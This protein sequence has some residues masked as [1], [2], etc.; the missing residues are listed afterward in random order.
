MT[1]KKFISM[2]A[3]MFFLFVAT[4]GSAGCGGGHSSLFPYNKPDNPTGSYT[5]A[6][7]S[8]GG[9]EIESQTVASG[10][11]AIMPGDP[12]KDNNLFMGWYTAEGFSFLFD[13]ETPIYENTVLFAKWYDTTDTTDSDGDGLMDSLEVMFGT[14]PNNRD[15]D[16]DGLTDYEELNWLN[17]N[18]LAQDTDGN[19]IP[20]GDEDPDGDMLLNIEEANL[21]TSFIMIDTDHD[22]I[23]DYDEVKIFKTNPLKAD[24]D[25]DGVDDGVEIALGT[26]PLIAETSFPTTFAT[27]KIS[28]GD[29]EAVDISVSVISSAEGAGTLTVNQANNTNNPLVSVNMPGY[30]AA[31]EISAKQFDSA[32]ITFTIGKEIGT[33]NENFQPTIYYLNEETGLL[34]E[35]EDQI[36]SGNKITASVSHFSIYILL[37][38]VE[39]EEAWDKDIKPPL[40]GETDDDEEATL[41]V[42]FVIDCSGSMQDN[43]RDR[44]APQLSKQFVSKLRDNQDKAAVVT[45]TDYATIRCELTTDKNKLNSAIDN[46]YYYGGTNGS[47]GLHSAIM[48]L[49][50]S[51]SEYK[52]VIFLTDGDDNYH[53]YSYDT[54]IQNASND[55][56]V[57]YTIGMGSAVETT[58]KKIADGTGGKYYKATTST[59]TDDILDLTTV[60]DEI[61]AETIDLTKDENNDGIP[62][63]YAQLMNDGQIKLENKIP[64]FTG[65]LDMYGDNDDWDGDGLKNGEEINI[66]TVTKAGDTE[67]YIEMKSNPLLYDSDFDGYSDYQEVIEMKTNPF[68]TTIAGGTTAKIAT[69]SVSST[70]FS[71]V[72]VADISKIS[73]NEDLAKLRDDDSFA[74]IYGYL[75]F[76][77][78]HDPSSIFVWDGNSIMD[79]DYVF[80]FHKDEKVM[81][82]LIDFFNDYTTQTNLEERNKRLQFAMLFSRAADVLE[83]TS[84]IIGVWRSIE[85]CAETIGTLGY[86]DSAIKGSVTKAENARQAAQNAKTELTTNKKDLL[87]SINDWSKQAD[88]SSKLTPVAKK[89]TEVENNIKSFGSSASSTVKNINNIAEFVAD[90][91]HINFDSILDTSSKTLKAASAIATLGN[92]S[93]KGVKNVFGWKKISNWNISLFRDNGMRNKVIDKRTLG[94]KEIGLTVT[95]VVD[96]INTVADVLNVV[97][98]YGTIYANYSEFQKYFEVLDFIENNL[99]LPKHVR[100]GAGKLTV[101]IKDTYSNDPDWLTFISEAANLTSNKITQNAFKIASDVLLTLGPTPV[102]LVMATFKLLELFNSLLGISSRAETL[103]AAQAYYALTSGSR[104]MMDSLGL[105]N[106]GHVDLQNGNSQEEYEKYAVQLAQSRI[107]GLNKIMKYL[108]DG[109]PA[110]YSDLGGLL[111]KK[112]TPEEIEE[113]YE[114]AIAE[115]YKVIKKWTLTVS[116]QLPFYSDYGTK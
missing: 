73:L 107:V 13:F 116:D 70:A 72:K 7:D 51:E 9:S 59:G 82:N 87:E 90:W 100:D 74:S 3:L 31:Y 36:I 91:E 43:D 105:L 34:E 94:G 25:E 99:A 78:L 77:M 86:S 5:V 27:S 56:I 110:S 62:D 64:Y 44:L 111:N 4:F 15:T 58:L 54:L 101:L 113:E 6:F 103:V 50:T 108:S 2:S 21:G 52:Y 16:D 98:T 47:D 79:S 97:A 24:T 89:I 57:V 67:V 84:N 18:P 96:T 55:K 29:E 53:R 75:Y 68:K 11:T 102:K 83:I 30:L 39:F 65:V 93:A 81:K 85:S 45:F 95:I 114:N 104:V 26:D 115:I 88:K 40:S 42:V 63:Y 71:N 46:V 61:Q 76:S 12:I 48:L 33:V 66:K 69:S 14:D 17:Y 106:N 8:L 19:G 92:L 28:S 10:D 20:D 49:E 109:S 22:T 38:K 60:F 1:N 80:D 35:V 23:S 112:R 37:N 41:D 32:S